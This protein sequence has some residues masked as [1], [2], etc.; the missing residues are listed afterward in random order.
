MAPKGTKKKQRDSSKREKG[1]QNEQQPLVF[2]EC[3]PTT[4]ASTKTG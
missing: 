1:N 2:I 3:V 4:P